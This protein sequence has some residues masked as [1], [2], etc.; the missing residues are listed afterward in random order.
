MKRPST[1][2]SGKPATVAG[3]RL[4]AWGP[5][6]DL[7]AATVRDRTPISRKTFLAVRSVFVMLAGLM[8]LSAPLVTAWQASEQ[9][10]TPRII[11]EQHVPG[12]D[13]PP[14]ADVQDTAAGG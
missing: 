4:A 1:P 10:H 2:P 6:V 11:R 12:R 14:P 3:P 13:A 8:L 7:A 9:V 5:A